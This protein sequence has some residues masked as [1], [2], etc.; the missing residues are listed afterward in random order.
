MQIQTNTHSKSSIV[1]LDSEISSI[2]VSP[3]KML[4]LQIIN[5][6]GALKQKSKSIDVGSKVITIEEC[7]GDKRIKNRK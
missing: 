7:I 2:S 6:N 4:F 3:F 1:I 5:K